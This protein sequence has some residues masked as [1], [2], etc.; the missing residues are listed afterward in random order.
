MGA[1]RLVVAV[2]ITVLLACPANTY[3]DG[4]VAVPTASAGV[5]IEF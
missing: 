5:L 1:S 3:R 2:K 4:R